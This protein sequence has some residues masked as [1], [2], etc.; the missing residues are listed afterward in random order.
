MN[1][2][3]KLNTICRKLC[4][5]FWYQVY[6]DKYYLN[7]GV[8]DCNI[9]LLCS[10]WNYYRK[11]YLD[12]LFQYYHLNDGEMIR[13]ICDESELSSILQFFLHPVLI[14]DTSLFSYFRNILSKFL[15]EG[16][17]AT[18]LN[19]C[20]GYSYFLKFESYD[21]WFKAKYLKS[22]WKNRVYQQKNCFGFS[23]KESLVRYMYEVYSV[24]KRENS[25]QC[26]IRSFIKKS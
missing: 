9:R 13:V 10:F 12:V 7:F 11:S 22:I 4:I 26:L 5:S 1:E 17:S 3:N 23:D 6:E 8:E 19:G 20:T 16:V 21:K 14:M 25:V 24:Q 2:I 18:F 15:E